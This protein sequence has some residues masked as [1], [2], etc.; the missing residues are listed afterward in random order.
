MQSKKNQSPVRPQAPHEV[1]PLFEGA[2]DRK[3]LER[4]E[5]EVVPLALLVL[6]G[7]LFVFVCGAC[8]LVM[9][10]GMVAGLLLMRLALPAPSR[11]FPT[12]KHTAPTHT[13][14]PV[15]RAFRHRGAAARKLRRERDEAGDRKLDVKL[16]GLCC[17]ESV[18]CCCLCCCGGWR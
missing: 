18:L 13:H 17:F 1:H 6:S 3:R 7:L 2:L 11:P 15:E 4:R 10:W 9:L 5:H 12:H 14:S 8:L 16:L